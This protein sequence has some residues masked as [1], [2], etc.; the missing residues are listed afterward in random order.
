MQNALESDCVSGYKKL[1]LFLLVNCMMLLPSC[2][3]S[4]AFIV[5]KKFL[6]SNQQLTR[7]LLVVTFRPSVYGENISQIE[8]SLAHSSGSLYF[9]GKLPTY[10]SPKPTFCPR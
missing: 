9:S 8:G 6:I 2:A 1:I 3:V 5:L 4:F 7:G 10:P